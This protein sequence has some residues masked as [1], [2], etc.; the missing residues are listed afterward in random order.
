M[1]EGAPIRDIG[2]AGAEGSCVLRPEPPEVEVCIVLLGRGT[3]GGQLIA[4][5]EA[6]RDSLRAGQGVSTRLV[7]VVD[8]HGVH[9]EPRGLL[10]TDLPPRSWPNSM[11]SGRSSTAATSPKAP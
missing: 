2:S 9:F 5:L 8:R 7:G 11:T 10:V 6:T 4:Q 1:R 3:V